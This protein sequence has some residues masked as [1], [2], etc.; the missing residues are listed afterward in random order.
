MTVGEDESTEVGVGPWPGERPAG[1]R[2]DPE[3]LELGDRRNVVDRYRYWSR[4]AVI[5]DLD[6][7]RHDFHVA[8]ENWQHDLNIGTVV[9]NAN[10]FLAAEVHIVGLR[11][12]NRRGAMV[13]DRYQHVRHHPTIEE[14]VGWAAGAGIP[15]IGIDNLPG[16]R[17]MET[18]TLPR[19]CVLLFGQEGPGL[20][21][22]ARGACSQLF[23]IAQYG[24]TRSINA[25]VASGI[26]MHAWIRAHAGPPPS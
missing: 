23:S 6:T 14:F 19:R 3:L 21:D 16:S 25:G 20:S 18:V 8:I 2:Y 1:D 7:R 26:A 22:A 9:R 11:K 15:V 17:P 10:A 4:D 13:T 5:A 24:S 12:W